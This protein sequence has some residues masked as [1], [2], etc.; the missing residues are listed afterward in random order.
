MVNR[1]GLGKRQM[2]WDLLNEVGRV[3]FE[4]RMGY[5]R[6][7]IRWILDRTNNR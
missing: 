5:R 1:G 2:D 6:C 3:G 7:S 4:G